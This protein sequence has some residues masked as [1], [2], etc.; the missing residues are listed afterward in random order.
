MSRPNKRGPDPFADGLIKTNTALHHVEQGGEKSLADCLIVLSGEEPG[1]RIYLDSS[2]VI[3]RG[4]DCDE[5]VLD[6]GI[7]RRHVMVQ[8]R[9]NGRYTV[10]D[11]DSRNGTRVNGQK[12]KEVVLEYGDEIAIGANTVLALAR[13]DRFEDRFQVAQKMQ[14]LGQLASG[15]SHDFNNLLGA[16][17]ANITF[18]GTREYDEVTGQCLR[19]MEVA[20]RRAVD[21]TRQLS[22]FGRHTV[23]KQSPVD[24]EALVQQ[25]VDLLRRTFPRNVEIVARI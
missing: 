23:S 11:L 18:L 6:A 16:L 21:L 15:V 14:A 24:M 25:A 20:I 19:E 3:G 9:P 10:T 1:R 5:I 2:I 7:S 13:R 22:E 8:R 12:I 17:F 4:E